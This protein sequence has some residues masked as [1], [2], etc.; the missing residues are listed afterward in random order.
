[1]RRIA[2]AAAL[3]SAAV[4]TSAMGQP[5]TGLYPS[6]VLAQS[7]AMTPAGLD[8]AQTRFIGQL[9]AAEGRY[10][11]LHAPALREYL[12]LL[13]GNRARLNL[14]QRGT[15]TPSAPD[16][17]LA[18]LFDWATALGL[19]GGGLVAES[20]LTGARAQLHRGIT[21]DGPL[22]LTY[23]PPYLTLT[24]P[25]LDWSIRFPYY[26]MI[27]SA[28]HRHLQPG[29]ETDVVML[30][31]L[32]GSHASGLTPREGADHSQATI[33]LVSAARADSAAFV[34]YWLNALGFSFSDLAPDSLIPGAITYRAPA[35]AQHLLKECV[36][37]ST[38]SGVL[39]VTYLGLP[40]TYEDNR[41]HFLALLRTLTT[42]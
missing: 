29:V 27:S 24:A 15:V 7:W 5:D 22:V 9:T 36:I 10:D 34:P 18:H 4:S 23:T 20:L 17:A 38:K 41:P 19:T 39:I 8:S 33:T 1:V 11:L 2:C 28:V 26:F 42:S 16:T 30:S 40:G 14:L 31:T 12:Y 21:P 6:S 13:I 37:V 3:V 35:N 32:W 25:K